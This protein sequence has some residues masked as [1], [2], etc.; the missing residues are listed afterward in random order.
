MEAVGEHIRH[1]GITEAVEEIGTHGH[2]GHIDPGFIAE[3]VSV[4]FER[5]FLRAYGF[6]SFPRE[7]SAGQCHEGGCESEDGTD[8]GVLVLRRTSCPF[9]DHGEGDERDEAHGVRADHT[10]GGELI[11]LIGILGHD[12]QQRSVGHIDHGVHDHHQQVEA[13]CPYT[14]AGRTEFRREQ[15]QRKDESEWDC[16]EDEPWAVRA[17]PGL[18]TVS[19]RAHERIGDHIEHTCDE[20][21][22]T[23]IGKRETEDVGKEHR[24]RY[25]HNLPGDAAG[26]GITQR[27]AYFFF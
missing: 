27:V 3:Q 9:L 2:E 1:D 5:E 24:E 17:P 11:T 20:H 22:H 23:G 19:N 4:L 14:F 16:A 18:R 26:S 6:M 12:V 13:V 21:E 8:D 10:E 7:Q 25:G 15:Q